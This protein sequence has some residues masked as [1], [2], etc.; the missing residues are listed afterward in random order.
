MN[1]ADDLKQE[2]GD[3]FQQ[4]TRL[5]QSVVTRWNST[6]YKIRRFLLFKTEV[7]KVL[8]QSSKAPTM[9]DGG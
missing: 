1:A 9:L 6:F 5:I 2:T 3:E 4:P 8:L 7:A